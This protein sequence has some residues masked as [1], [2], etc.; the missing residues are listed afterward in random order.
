MR[1][2]LFLSFLSISS[3]AIPAAYAASSSLSAINAAGNFNIS[4][5]P[6]N[7]S[8][9]TIAKHA[10]VNAYIRHHTLYL[11]SHTPKLTKVT[12]YT[13]AID[14]L[15]VNGNTSITANALQSH[16]L[17]LAANTRGKITLNGTALKLNKIS[18]SG[19]SNIS[20][21]WATGKN[22]ALFATGNSRIALAGNVGTVRAKLAG[23]SFLNA[24]Y[25]RAQ[26][27][28]LKTRNFAQAE[29]I[30]SNSL[31]AYPSDSSNI[32]YYK[33]PKLLNPMNSQSGNTL[34]LGWDN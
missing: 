26:H 15:T 5:L 30:S 8:H 10:N 16:G 31:Q 2:A 25:L 19:L 34:Q 29:V 14:R 32:Y 28:W 33:T 9:Y 20:L 12:V 22:I 4:I 1:K 11:R 6:A 7:S 13:N 3:L 27:T 17:I 24:K 23:H 18:A 21:K